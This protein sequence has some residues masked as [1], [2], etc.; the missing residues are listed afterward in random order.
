MN[1]KD[2]KVYLQRDPG[3][4]S[5]ASMEAEGSHTS[6]EE[7]VGSEREAPPQP[8]LQRRTV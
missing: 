7:S 6:P 8:V 4:A 2:T 3:V 5:R 1:N